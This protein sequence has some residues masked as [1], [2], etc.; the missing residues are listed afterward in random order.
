MQRASQSTDVDSQRQGGLRSDILKRIRLLPPLHVGDLRI[1]TDKL[2]RNIRFG[3][4]SLW[5]A[6]GFTW[7]AVAMIALGV[8]ANTAVFS[9][10]SAVVLRLLP[11]HNSHQLVF[12]RTTGV[13]GGSNLIE[14]YSAF[15]WPVYQILRTRRDVFS[16]VIAFAP[17]SIDKINA[18]IGNEPFEAEA[19]MVSSNF[20]S[21]LQVDMALGRGFNS[22]DES[23]GA[24][25]IVLSHKFWT[26][27]FSRDPGVIGK[28]IFVKGMPFS[29][30]GVAARGFEGTE[31]GSS[32]DF[33]IPLLDRAELNVF[34]ASPEEAK[35]YQHNPT[36]W[37]LRLIARLAPGMTR[38]QALSRVQTAFQQAAYV[39]VNSPRKGEPLPVLSFEDAKNFR[40]FEDDYGRPL[41]ML[42]ILVVFVLLIAITNVVLLLVT[43]NASRQR[44]FCLRMALGAG[45]AQLFSQLLC[46]AVLLVSVAGILAWA[47]A[48]GATR[49]LAYWAQ[50]ESSLTPD[51]VVLLFTLGLL[52][53]AAIVFALAPFRFAVGKN[54]AS[55]LRT[56]ATTSRS[57]ISTT[58][59][60]KT[61]VTLQVSLCVVL[62][63]SSGLLFRTLQNVEN[64]SLGIDTD[65]LLVFSLNPHHLHSHADT[66]RFY[67]LLLD[68]LRAM[69]LVKSAG[70]ILNR[71][72]ATVSSA[73]TAKVDGKIPDVPLTLQ[74]GS[75]LGNLESNE[76]GP[77]IFRTLGVPVLQGREFSDADSAD[78]PKVAIVNQTF[79]NSFLPGQN[80]LGHHVDD[81][82]II[83]VVADH[84]YTRMDEWPR[85]MAWWSYAQGS[86][87]GEVN[88]ELRIRG[89]AMSMLPTIRKVV[90]QANPDLPLINPIL[91]RD[92]FDET[93]SNK[94][95][96]ARLAEFFGVLAILLVATGLYGTLAF[97][98]NRR[99]GE[100]GVRMAMGALRGQ[101]LWLILRANL[102]LTAIG[103]CMG[104]PLAVL[105]SKALSS[106]LYGV[107]PLDARSYLFAVG[108]LCVVAIVSSVVPASRAARVDP[109]RALRTE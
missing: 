28:T 60:G 102:M 109:V 87:A 71:P 16:D 18:R 99:T 1:W 8:G 7:I 101:I 46:E 86:S 41:R 19:D 93:I 51:R 91:Q 61:I 62:L 5:Q 106:S 15:S 64:I 100:I 38:D 21:G 96:F 50:I 12:L 105:A 53:L 25:V 6:P 97:Q 9:V 14:E 69:P 17:P 84:K 74:P 37:C 59:L 22:R 77:Q 35:L 29:V 103:V 66:V 55:A 70:I 63:V 36:W 52:S 30:V 31:A 79:V 39:G 72:G 44:E 40:G 20:F 32:L 81:S 108:V 10:M 13:P 104:L 3:T 98:V 83:G 33:W 27:R 107:R 92:Q 67:Q 90:S 65:G 54:S 43:R 47:F 34:G 73:W 26:R 76:V 68:K 24:Q 2:V 89:D 49:L 75:L 80:P 48:E 85:P 95:L 94:L 42:M 58:R 88:I 82:M 56:F 4:R 78:A 45:P 11:V 23:N 57:D